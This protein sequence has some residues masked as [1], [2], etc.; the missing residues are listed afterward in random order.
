MTSR[1]GQVSKFYSLFAF[2]IIPIESFETQSADGRFVPMVP[3][4][5][6]IQLTFANRAEY[7]ERA[8]QYRM[9][10]MDRQ[11]EA[12]REGMAW[13]IPVPLLSLLTGGKLEQFVCG[14]AEVN[15]DVF[16]KVVR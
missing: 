14:S 1:P 12:I 2:Q 15:I 5:E 13:I 11:V 8:L 4:G 7:V 10:E 6:N 16:K 3:S 9:H